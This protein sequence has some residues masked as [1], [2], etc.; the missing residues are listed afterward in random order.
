[1]KK[2]ILLN[3]TI[4]GIFLVEFLWGRDVEI[5]Y[6]DNGFMSYCRS[7]EIKNT[8]VELYVSD[9]T[10]SEVRNH[11]LSGTLYPWYFNQD[12]SLPRF[13]L[14]WA[15]E[16]NILH[17]VFPDFISDA[18][19]RISLL[20]NSKD[21]ITLKA[22]HS[23]HDD[24]IH[25]QVLSSSPDALAMTR[26]WQNPQIIWYDISGTNV[27]A[28]LP[29]THEK[30]DAWLPCEKP[31][32]YKWMEASFPSGKILH[33]EDFPPDGN[34]APV[35]S[36]RVVGKRV[37]SDDANAKFPSDAEWLIWEADGDASRLCQM[38][39]GRWSVCKDAPRTDAPKIIVIDNDSNYVFLLYSMGM[40]T[41]D[42][43]G[44]FKKIIAFLKEQDVLGKKEE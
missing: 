4:L 34:F 2:Y 31:V 14:A 28:R 1:M 23:P 15:I 21:I 17:I 26:F 35:G 29:M 12:L 8:P 13:P 19:G 3:V 40:D 32:K 38:R 18:I 22:K 16:K 6:I 5:V 25:F 10:F 33:S 7:L 27:I 37:L 39:E 42:V 11:S 44:S 36:V 41:E 43:E 24:K 30:A 9:I 20:V